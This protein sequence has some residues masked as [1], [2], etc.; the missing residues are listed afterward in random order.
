MQEVPFLEKGIGMTSLKAN[1]QVIRN[2]QIYMSLLDK[3]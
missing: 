1:R 3:Q 2:F